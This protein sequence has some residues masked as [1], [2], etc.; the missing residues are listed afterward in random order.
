MAAKARGGKFWSEQCQSIRKYGT[1]QYE[2][3]HFRATKLENYLLEEAAAGTYD[4]FNI[5]KS[6]L[7]LFSGETCSN[8]QGVFNIRAES[9][10]VL[11]NL[12][13]G[14]K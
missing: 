5:P 3:D 2:R 8:L 11:A 12:I 13:L 7:D 6:F 9:L 10:N 14:R 4:V 1:P